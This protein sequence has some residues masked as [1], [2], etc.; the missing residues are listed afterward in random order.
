MVAD[1]ILHDDLNYTVT[2][3]SSLKLGEETICLN[4]SVKLTCN[5][6]NLDQQKYYI[7]WYW[8]D[9]SKEGATLIVQATQYKVVYTCKVSNNNGL[10]G[11]ASITVAANGE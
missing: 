2:I 6:D 1:A 11:E 7:T 4:H 3:V 9:Q 8:S 10:L 5:A